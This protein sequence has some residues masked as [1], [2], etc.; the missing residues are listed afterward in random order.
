MRKQAFKPFQA[1]L[2][3]VSLSSA[4][5]GGCF[6]IGSSPGP[7]PL[8]VATPFNAPLADERGVTTIAGSQVRGFR[9]GPAMEAQ[10]DGPMGIAINQKTGDLFVADRFNHRIRRINSAGIVSTFAGG[11]AG[12]QDGDRETARFKHPFDIAIDAS[13]SLYVADYSNNAIRKITPSGN[14]S[15]LA[16]DGQPGY[17]D[18]RGRNARFKGPQSLT[19]AQDGEIFVADIGNKRVRKVTPDGTVTTL[20]GNSEGAISLDY[21]ALTTTASKTVYVSTSAGDIIQVAE[22]GTVSSFAG[23]RTLGTNDGPKHVAQFNLIV[24]MTLDHAGFLYAS[25]VGNCSIRMIEIEGSVTRGMVTTVPATFRSPT[26]LALDGQGNLYV[27][28]QVAHCIRR[29]E[30]GVLDEQK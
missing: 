17:A 14:V 13:G 9:D 10:F 30:R 6:S 21:F 20:A 11:E 15:T 3:I 25:D 27:A 5:V 16:G 8:P 7:S 29:I 12:Y 4:I 26:G 18:A 28:D 19:I 22:D 23:S 2:L 24:G 1:F